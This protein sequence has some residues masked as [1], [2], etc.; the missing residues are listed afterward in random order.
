MNNRILNI[1]AGCWLAASLG[2]CSKKLDLAPISSI[3]ESG[4]W[5]SPEQVQA[6]VNGIHASFRSGTTSFIYL[7]EMRADIF[8]TDPG[9]SSVFTGEATQGVERLWLNNLDMDAPGVSNYG[10]FYF[11]INQINLLIDKLNTTN[12]VSE[13]DK[14][15]F[16]G[17]A[18]GLRAFYY[19]QMLRSWGSVIIQTTPSTSFD[20]S[21]LAKAASPE[22][23]VLQLVKDDLAK[24]ESAFGT[25]YSFRNRSKA[26]WSKPATLMLKA[27]LSLW[28]AHRSGGVADATTAKNALI[29]IQSNA[30]L[31]LLPVYSNVFTSGN[32]DNLEMIFAAR[33]KLDEATLPISGTFLPQSSLLAS[34]YDSVGNRKFTATTDNWNGLLRAPIKIATF[35]RFNDLDTRKWASIQPAYNKTAAGTYQIAGAFV[36]KFEGE[37][38]A[39][40]RAYTNDFPVYRYADLL[41]LLAEAKVLLGEDPAAEINQVRQRA[42]GVNYNVD[43]HGFPN[44]AI[45]GNPMEAILEERFFEF[46]FEGKRW[47]DLRRMGDNFV[48]ANTTV[49]ASESYKLLWPIDRN[50]LTN[51]RELK[52]TP[53]YPLF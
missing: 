12:I 17:Q 25:D 33:N 50:T 37:Q 28:T 52:Q 21:N 43:L 51:N 46:V 31:G 42:Y 13:S 11:N 22:A 44:Q 38:N 7:G 29:E 10:G 48:Y 24:S 27:E 26:F 15:Y 39:G 23:E 2:A 5:Q 30:A 40:S 41:L 35:R 8:G 6:F 49:S 18:H 14:N 9:S 36:K 19:F 4:Y 1:V 34:Y 20:I 32:K 47:H 3:G 16:L 45:D 53:G